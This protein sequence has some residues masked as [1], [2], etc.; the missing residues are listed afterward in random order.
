MSEDT[1]TPNKKCDRFDDEFISLN[2]GGIDV[3][4]CIYEEIETI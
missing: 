1:P 4:P 3:D 2:I